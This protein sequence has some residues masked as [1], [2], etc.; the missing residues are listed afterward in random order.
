M[1]NQPIIID[2]EKYHFG[3]ITVDYTSYSG[4]ITVVVGSS[5]AGAT[6][7]SLPP[8]GKTLFIFIDITF[9]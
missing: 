8:F 6:E 2:R 1:N 4:Y 5:S 7:A 3:I 9:D